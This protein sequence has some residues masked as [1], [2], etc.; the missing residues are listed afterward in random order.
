MRRTVPRLRAALTATVLLLPI[1]AVLALTSPASADTPPAGSAGAAVAAP[2]NPAD[3][4]LNQGKRTLDFD[5]GWKFQ[6]V[7]T[8]GTTDPTGQYGNSDN[9]L[10]AAPGFDDSS[11][12]SVTLPHE[13]VRVSERDADR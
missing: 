6:L 8:T 1:S 7:G 5:H 3:G 4:V 13:L 12:R 9:P 11:W 10:A 2:A